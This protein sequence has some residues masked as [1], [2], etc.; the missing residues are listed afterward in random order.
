[1][2]TGLLSSCT[3]ESFDEGLVSSLERPVKCVSLNN[4]PSLTR[5][6][7]V[8]T[9]SDKTLFYPFTVSVN[10]CGGSCNTND[11]SYA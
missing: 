7:I 5:P 3:I 9:N 2:L 1:M 4:Q 6:I 8:N 10:K 11:D